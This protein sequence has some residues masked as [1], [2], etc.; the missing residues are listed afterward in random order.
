M[1][2]LT[3]V[4]QWSKH[5]PVNQRVAGLIPSQVTCLGCRPGPQ[6]RVYEKQPYLSHIDISLPLFLPP[7]PSL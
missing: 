6:L 4:A 3:G 5:Q 2:T 7:F 1:I